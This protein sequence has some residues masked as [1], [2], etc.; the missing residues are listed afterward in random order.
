MLRLASSKPLALPTAH[1]PEAHTGAV[2][3]LKQDTEMSTLLKGTFLNWP[4]KHHINTK[5][6]NP[7]MFGLGF[8]VAVDSLFFNPTKAV[9]DI[10][11]AHLILDLR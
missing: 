8:V 11:D 5:E 3:L 6:S 1:S 4:E 10:L 7:K 9:T 2:F